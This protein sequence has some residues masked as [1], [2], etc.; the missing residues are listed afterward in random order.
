M[1]V[2]VT[3][4]DYDDTPCMRIDRLERLRLKLNMTPRLAKLDKDWIYAFQYYNY[5][6]VPLM[7]SCR[8]C[9]FKVL[10]F[11]EQHFKTHGY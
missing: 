1:T 4:K 10:D 7:M 6:N 9:Y 5:Y 8:P 11:I 3:V 2:V